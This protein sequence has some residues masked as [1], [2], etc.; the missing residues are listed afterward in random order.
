MPRLTH[1]LDSLWR[2]FTQAPDPTARVRVSQ[3]VIDDVVTSIGQLPA[4]TGAMLGADADGVIRHV[5]FDSTADTT[6]GTYTPDTDAMNRLLRDEWRPRGVEL[7]GFVHSHPAGNTTPSAGDRAYASRILDAIPRIDRL[8]LPIVQ[9]RPDTSRVVLHPFTAERSDAGVVVERA[10]LSVE[11]GR[12][13]PRIDW[14]HDDAFARV[15]SA[16]S[17]PLLARCRLIVVGAGGSA[18]WVET[19]VRQGVGE[20]VLIDPDVVGETNLATQQTYRRD[21]GKPK[22]FALADR[23]RD[24]NPWVSVVAL[25]RS[26]DEISDTRFARLASVPLNGRPH[27][28]VVMVCALT[29]HFWAQARLNRLAL[30]LGLPVMAAQVYQEGRGA[31]VSFAV[32]GLTP[33]CG[34]C[35]LG[36]RYRAWL[37]QGY[38]T[39]G[40]SHG[41]PLPATDRLNSLKGHVALAMLHGA[42]GRAWAADP[43]ARRWRDLL[44][45]IAH[46]N[47]AQVRLDPDLGHSLG[48]SVFD[49]TFERAE[50]GR[51]VC[52]ETLWLPQ[53]PERPDTGW[54][55]CPDCGG[56]GDLRDAIGTIDRTDLRAITPSVTEQTGPVCAFRSQPNPTTGEG[57]EP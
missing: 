50:R 19:M 34:R 49:R 27:P 30:N 48:V 39:P 52:D 44:D 51:V 43:A 37:D 12:S 42:A 33:A 5:R 3:R 17:L 47:L 24:I 53:E 18:A 9:T 41:T 26:L 14:F 55:A 35:V 6:G 57:G 22:V 16:V 45:L 4:E 15:A 10:G 29:D 1:P 56:T 25:A 20:V 21:L 7:A 8:F 11:R 28:E 46:R 2:L 23:L 38:S 36:G 54:P 31:E 40:V 13:T 32:P